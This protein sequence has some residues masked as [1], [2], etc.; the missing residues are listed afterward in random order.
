MITVSSVAVH[1]CFLY[2]NNTYWAL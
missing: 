2:K 1:G